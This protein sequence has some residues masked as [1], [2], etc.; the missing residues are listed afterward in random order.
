MNSVVLEEQRAEFKAINP[1]TGEIVKTYE[2]HTQQ[3][4][5]AI[6][7]TASEAFGQWRWTDF[8]TRA[9]LMRQAPRCQVPS[10]RR[11]GGQPVGIAF[12]ATSMVVAVMTDVPLTVALPPD[13]PDAAL[14]RPEGVP[15]GA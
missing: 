10:R 9:D 13:L 2:G 5:N 12:H 8:E 6:L 7:Q 11:A 3:E 14:K 1:S 15:P 4:V